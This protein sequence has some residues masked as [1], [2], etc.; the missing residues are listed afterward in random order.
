MHTGGAFFAEDDGMC[1]RGMLADPNFLEE[2]KVDEYYNRAVEEIEM[3]KGN[4]LAWLNDNIDD[5]KKL[6]E[7]KAYLHNMFQDLSERASVYYEGA[8]G[9][10]RA[11]SD[12]L[13]KFK[14]LYEESLSFKQDILVDIGDGVL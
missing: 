1:E 12:Q 11:T 7:Q 5:L 4:I 6:R 10:P 13:E 14:V 8:R 9:S 3:V 2:R